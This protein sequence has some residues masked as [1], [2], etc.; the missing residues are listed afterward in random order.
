M[1]RVMK[2]KFFFQ[3]S[4]SF[5]TRPTKYKRILH[6]FHIKQLYQSTSEICR[7]KLAAGAI[8]MTYYELVTMIF[9]TSKNSDIWF[10]RSEQTFGDNC[11]DNRS[12]FSFSDRKSVEIVS[13]DILKRKN[14]KITK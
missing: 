11:F 5:R 4:T 6:V 12:V 14:N 9:F 1:Q 8:P 13:I 10:Q 7:E 3:L 2:D